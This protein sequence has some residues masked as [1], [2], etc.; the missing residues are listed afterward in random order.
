MKLSILALGLALASTGTVAS[1]LAADGSAGL[2]C[3]AR[4][5]GA[6]KASLAADGSLNLSVDG[7]AET[8]FAAQS[9][10]VVSEADW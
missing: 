2:T 4:D 6:S 7:Q 9:R 10:K 5:N 3:T 8:S 1:A